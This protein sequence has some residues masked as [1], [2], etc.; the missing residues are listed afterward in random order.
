M[1]EF[2]GKV[3]IVTGSSS[4]IGESIARRLADLGATV[5][6]N[7]SS[8]VE[9]GEAV[10]KSL[11]NGAIYV[12]ADISKKDEALNLLEQT[13][14]AFGKL[15]IL[16]NNAGWT[17]PVPHH[18]LDALTDEIFLKTFE[19]NV[20]GTWYLSKAAIPYLK[21]SEDGN[22]VNITSIAGVRQWEVQWRI[23]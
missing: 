7:S 2:Q 9:A 15:D 8:S 12:R 3:V 16:V 5:V 10:A 23:P 22:I 18:D 14:K 19:V 6:V 4:G 1:S 11:P 13:I 20:Y 17:T 21:Q